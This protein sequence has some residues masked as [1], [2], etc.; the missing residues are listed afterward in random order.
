MFLMYYFTIQG[1]FFYCKQLTEKY[2]TLSASIHGYRYIW[3]FSVASV[4]QRLLAAVE[5]GE[6]S[7]KCIDESLRRI[8]RVKMKHLT[9]QI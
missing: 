4:Y 5:K 1:S 7:E 3:T 2:F 8:L 6:L 9:G